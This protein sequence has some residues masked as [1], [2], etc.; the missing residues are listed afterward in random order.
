[1]IEKMRVCVVMAFALIFAGLGV[2]AETNILSFAYSTSL[3]ADASTPDPWLRKLND[4]YWTNSVADGVKY[5]GNVIVT[6]DLARSTRLSKV[7]VYTFTVGG[8]S[9]LSTQGV[10]LECSND[11]A[12]WVTLGT[13]SAM[14]NGLFSGGAFF[15]NTRYLRLTCVKGGGAAGQSLAEIVV[16][17]RIAS[18]SGLLAYSY[19]TS[20]PYNSAHTDPSMAKLYDGSWTNAATQSV[21]YGPNST[22]NVNNSDPAFCIASNVVVVTTFSSVRTVRSAS[23]L[24][25]RSISAGGYGTARVTLSNSLDG[26]TWSCAGVQTNYEN[27]FPGYY[28]PNSVRFDFTMPNVDARYLAFAFE[29]VTNTNIVRQLLGEI[30][31]NEAAPAAFLGD[32][33]AFTY[34]FSK[35]PSVHVDRTDCPKLTDGTWDSN[36]RN[37]VRIYGDFSITADLGMP[38]YVAGTDLLCWSNNFGQETGTYSTGRVVVNGSLDKTNWT[39]VADITRW[40]P[41]WPYHHAVTFTNTMPYARYLRFDAYRCS[42]TESTTNTA[43]IM[44]EL[45]IYRPPAAVI[46]ALPVDVTNAIQNAGF[47]DSQIPDGDS[48]TMLVRGGVTNGWTFSYAN[49]ANYAGF[50]RNNS[51]VSTNYINTGYYLRY[52]APEGKQTAVLMGSGSMETQISVPTNGTYAL[53][54]LVNSTVFASA[55]EAGGYDFRV[56]LDGVDKSVETVLQLTNTTHEVFLA[57]VSAG[58][59]TLRFE[60]VNS[61]SLT[62]GA[63]IDNLKLKRYAVAAEQVADQGRGFMFVAGAA[64]PLELDYIGNILIKE[65]WLDSVLM[66]PAKYS[67]LN[68]PS[69]FEGPGAIRYDR[70]TLFQVR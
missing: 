5:G 35:A 10:T 65:L 53:Q 21:Q 47:E 19:T 60:G 20:M 18:T 6:V 16:A 26:L 59:H 43:Q 36:T 25:F 7:D 49:S 52:I 66:P 48:A 51:P 9:Q 31:I 68:R 58:S 34:E 11:A 39:Q 15:A 17:G 27:S 44:G 14:S 42:D 61:K 40:S 57:S 30:Q 32:P 62:W 70:G 54:F 4:G 23:I 24:A 12:T 13:L 22:T 8:S 46:G 28:A 3:A 64:T 38:R 1:M 50:Q 37:A 45:T 2:A 55:T 56:K 33:L 29:K 41:S 63:L 69:M 67:A